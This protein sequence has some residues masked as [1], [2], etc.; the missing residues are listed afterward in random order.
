MKGVLDNIAEVSITHFCKF[1]LFLFYLLLCIVK[2]KD[3]R[4]KK[5]IILDLKQ[6]YVTGVSKKRWRA[7]LPRVLDLVCDARTRSPCGCTGTVSLY[8]QLTLAQVRV[9]VSSSLYM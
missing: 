8:L 7:V 1:P 4:T 6:S 9:R 5:R 3:G 2:T